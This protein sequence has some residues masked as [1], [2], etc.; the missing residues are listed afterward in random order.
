MATDPHILSLDLPDPA[1]AFAGLAGEAGAILLDGAAAGDPARARY[2]Y[3]C[4]AP[5]RWL[6]VRDGAV[7]LD[8]APAAGDPF[9][10]MQGL[11]GPVQAAVAGLPPFQGGLAG[12]L[13]YELGRQLERLPPAQPAGIDL[14]DLAMGLY[15][16]VAAWDHATG[17]SWIIA[18]GADAEAQAAALAERLRAGAAAEDLSG[19]DAPLLAAPGWRAELAPDGYRAAVSRILEYIRAGDIYQANMT[20]RFLGRC[21]PGTTPWQAYRRLRPRTAAPFSAFLNLGRGRA[22]ASGSP[23]RFLRLGADGGIET[24][25]IKGTRPRGA[26]AAEDERLARDLLASEKDRAEN[27]M[28]VDL[29]RNDLSR[30]ATVGS[31]RV[32]SLWGLE[33]YRTVHHLTSVVT[34]AL[35]PG[36]G[37]VDL[38]RAAF[39]GG[40]I[41]G[42]PKIR[43]MEIIRELEPARRG[44]YCGSVAWIGRDGAMDSSIVIRTLAFA[45][46]LVQ[47]QAGGGIVADSDPEAEYQECLTKVLAMLTALDPAMAWPPVAAYPGGGSLFD[48][49]AIDVAAE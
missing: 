35:R 14:P 30:V 34:A 39:P 3:V 21:A 8:G 22:I 48:G 25:P 23:E 38:L 12:Y 49:T 36:L 29:L 6:E 32:P 26:T 7:L 28:I 43:A 20:Q 19:E 15:D 47:A 16:L 46:G 33:S 10:L 17:Q 1:A 24:R 18:R 37:P 41:T 42:A 40:S 11:L 13:G 44:P 2:S 27:L 31:V 9:A 4:I 5:R 45:G